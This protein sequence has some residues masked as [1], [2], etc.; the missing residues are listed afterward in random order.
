MGGLSL[1]EDMRLNV[2]IGIG[3]AAARFG[4][5]IPRQS[6]SLFLFCP[7]EEIVVLLLVIPR[8]VKR[9]MLFLDLPLRLLVIEPRLGLS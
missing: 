4:P 1:E 2:F 5:L 9:L 3:L 6:F 7:D 8:P